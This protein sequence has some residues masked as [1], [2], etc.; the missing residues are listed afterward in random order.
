MKSAVYICLIFCIY[1][2]LALKFANFKES[3]HVDNPDSPSFVI[4]GNHFEKDGQPF[5]VVSGIR[6]NMI[7][8]VHLQKT[9]AMHY[10]R[11]LPEQWADRLSKMKLGGLNT[12]FKIIIF[13][14]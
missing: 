7:L 4:N 14:Y 5:T 8:D 10:F 9:G 12:V 3:P 2:A 6:S 13:R 11:V 1:G